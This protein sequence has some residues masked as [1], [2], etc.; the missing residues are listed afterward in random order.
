MRLE[1]AERLGATDLIDAGDPEAEA[2]IMELTGGRG[3]D[4]AFECAGAIPALQ[5]ALRIT[6]NGGT[7]QLLSLIHI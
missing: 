1:L 7:A 5:M 6:R 4:V 2:R 3:V